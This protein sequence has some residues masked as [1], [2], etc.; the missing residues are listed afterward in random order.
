MFDKNR[1]KFM[2]KMPQ[3][4]Y[5]RLC[6]GE[7]KVKSADEMYPFCPSMDFYYL[8]GISEPYIQLVVTSAG[9]E[10]L[11]VERPDPVM[12]KWV[13][14]KL[15]K[16]EALFLSG[17]RKV[18]YLDEMEDLLAARTDRPLTEGEIVEIVTP[19]R[20]VKEDMELMNIQRAVEITRA[21]LESMMQHVRPGMKEYEVE[22]YFDYE[23]RRHGVRDKSFATI[24]AGGDNGCVLHYTEN[25]GSLFEGQLLLVD[26]GAR[27][28]QYSGDLTRTFPVSGKFTERQRQIYNIVLEGQQRVIDAIEP[29]VPFASL[30]ELLIDYYFEALSEIGLVN[31]RED[32]K[33]YYYH[34]VSHFLGLDTHDVGDRVNTILEPGM[35]LTV[36]PGLYIEEE[37]IGIRIEDDV[38]V[39]ETAC[40][41]FAEGLPK[42]PDAIEAFMA[43]GK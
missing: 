25:D 13:G 26:C 5:A 23:L 30:N 38:L 6:S 34:S 41:I 1:R 32:V 12:A 33:K 40:A 21:G 37:G 36:E 31:T 9:E 20:L 42:D 2:D 7:P 18:Y 29:G 16:V 35:V 24:C 19:L 43:E 8:T 39:T 27:F 17:V 14:E 15:T 10:M 3:N 11:F 22:A 4:T 28:G